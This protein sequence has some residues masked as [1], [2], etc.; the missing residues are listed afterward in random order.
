LESD[1]LNL[2]VAARFVAVVTEHG[3]MASVVELEDPMDGVD[4]IPGPPLAEIAE[5]TDQDGGAALSVA[6]VPVTL[7]GLDAASGTSPAGCSPN[8]CVT[9]TTLGPEQLSSTRAPL[10]PSVKV[11][12]PTA[13][14]ASRTCRRGQRFPAGPSLR[15]LPE[16]RQLVIVPL[17]TRTTP[18]MM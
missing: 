1:E 4:E 2:T 5:A 6:A 13:Q 3:A 17:E 14:Q 7:T 10:W 15:R 9:S 8:S 16:M 12:S 11:V 18:R